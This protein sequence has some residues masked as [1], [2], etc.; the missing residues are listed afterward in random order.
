MGLASC[1]YLCQFHHKDND[2]AVASLMDLTQQAAKQR[3][4]G[5]AATEQ[6]QGGTVAGAEAGQLGADCERDLAGRLAGPAAASAAQH[7]GP[8]P[9]HAAA[10]VWP[11]PLTVLLRV[12]LQVCERL[13]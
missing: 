1:L 6:G 11:P 9:L 3:A 10:V 13:Q 7:P 12:V 2:S 5:P 4:E 8:P